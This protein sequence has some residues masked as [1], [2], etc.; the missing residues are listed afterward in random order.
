MLKPAN[1]QQV[2]YYSFALLFILSAFLVGSTGEWYWLSVPFLA[3]LL[4]MSVVDFKKVF[5]LLLFC[6]PFSIEFYF[7]GGIGTDLPSEPL[8]LLTTGIGLLFFAVKAPKMNG[9]FFRHPVTLLLLL[10]LAWIFF[11]TLTSSQ[12]M[13]SLKFFL[14]K[15]WYLGAFY[16][17]AAYL[18]RNEKSLKTFFWIW[19]I[20]ITTTV[21]YVLVRH[22]AVGFTFKD[23]HF[24]MGPFYRNHVMYAAV[25]VCFLPFLWYARGWILNNTLGK[26]FWVGV[27]LILLAGVQYSFTRA[28][29]VAII[30]AFV[31]YFIIKWRLMLPTL[32]ISFSVALLLVGFLA[33]KNTFLDYAPDYERTVTHTRFTNLVEATYKMEDIST[34]ERVY[35]WVAGAFM[36]V[37]KPVVG[38]G[39]GNFFTFYKSYSVLR[40][41]TYVSDNPDKSGIHNYY[42]MTAVDQGIPGLIIFLALCFYVLLRGERVYH[43]TPPGWRRRIVMAALMSIII[44]DALLLINDMVETD[45]VGS[46]F[47]INMALIVRMDLLNRKERGKTEVDSK[48]DAVN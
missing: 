12:P 5:F 19:V 29:Y 7:P 27:L 45:K 15:F 23:V 20:A 9:A 22:A 21:V 1:A 2:I 34:M 18:L 17:L 26:V 38:F 25:I 39:P 37:E 33:Y 41:K 24:V 11:T 10:H 31:A 43:E 3:I 48:G 42:L 35:R 30:L 40:F 16:F 4:W 28:A 32:A 47:F 46:F 6:I 13:V 44:I 36:V 14:A 8:M